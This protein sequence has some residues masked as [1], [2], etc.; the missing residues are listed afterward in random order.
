MALKYGDFS[1]IVFR[2]LQQRALCAH[3]ECDVAASDA[4]QPHAWLY[5]QKGH[6]F[7]GQVNLP[8]FGDGRPAVG[9]ALVFNEFPGRCGIPPPPAGGGHCSVRLDHGFSKDEFSALVHLRRCMHLLR[10]SRS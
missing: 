10:V 9:A 6:H 3:C 7:F 5:C 8:F 1:V 2:L 4:E